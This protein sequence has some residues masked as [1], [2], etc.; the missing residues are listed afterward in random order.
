MTTTHIIAGLFGLQGMEF[1]ILA[2]LILVFFGAKKLPQLA[3]GLGKSVTE[4]RRAKSEYDDQ[5]TK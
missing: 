2:V 4:F 5:L 3:R 1:I